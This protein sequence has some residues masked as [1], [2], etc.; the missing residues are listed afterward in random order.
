MHIRVIVVGE[1]MNWS[2]GTSRNIRGD[3]IE[4]TVDKLMQL[5][6]SEHKKI[7]FDALRNANLTTIRNLFAVNRSLLNSKLH[8][9]EGTDV[10]DTIP[11][12][13]F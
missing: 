5:D 2:G 4:I 8:G 11:N 12:V 3:A 1:N 7:F 9:Y 13:S 6:T 10:Y